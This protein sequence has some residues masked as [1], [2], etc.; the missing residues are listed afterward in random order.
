MYI[1]IELQ[2]TGTRTSVLTYTFVDV[3][4]AEQKYHTILSYAAVS[5]VDFHAAS[6]L[7]PDGSLIK[8][9]YYYHERI[10]EVN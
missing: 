2:T 8:N 10:E 9:E 6:I 1:V 3:N 7:R 5:T 4:E